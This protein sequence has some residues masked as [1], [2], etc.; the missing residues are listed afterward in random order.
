MSILV[1]TVPRCSAAPAADP[2][3]RG[4]LVAPAPDYPQRE[5]DKE[6]STFVHGTVS[7]GGLGKQPGEA[8]LLRGEV[9]TCEIRHAGI[10]PLVVGS[11]ISLNITF[12][13]NLR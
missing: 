11:K 6:L 10:R 12:N 3:P 5:A 2:G 8:H 13:T 1:E 4:R 7:G 9:D